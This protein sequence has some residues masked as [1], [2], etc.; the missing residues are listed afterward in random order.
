MLGQRLALPLA[1]RLPVTYRRGF[2]DEYKPN[3][4]F[5]L[6]REL[7]EELAALGRLPG[8]L[9]AGTYVRK[10]LEQL[11]TAFK[12]AAGQSAST[13][14]RLALNIATTPCKPSG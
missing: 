4:T 8:Q 7:A 10:V 1:A 2:V 13:L 14:P 11:L 3:E 5:L 12:L 9:P 6:P